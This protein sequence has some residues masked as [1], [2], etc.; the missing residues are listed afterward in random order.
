MNKKEILIQLINHLFDFEAEM[1]EQEDYTLEDFIGYMNSQ[2]SG[3]KSTIRKIG[4]DEEKWI[5]EK[6]VTQNSDIAVLLV[7]M[8]RY[9]KVYFKKAIK[10]SLIQ[11]QDEFSFLITLMTF[12]S[13]TKTE[14]IT[15]QIMEKT[16]GTEV[17]KRLLA[18]NLLKEFADPVDKRSVRVAVTD[19]GRNEIFKIL[20]DMGL[21]SKVV[22]GNL[23]ETETNT[24]AYLLKKLDHFH[25]DIYLNK[26]N[27]D[28]KDLLL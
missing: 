28:L 15:K 27:S 11:T 4:G 6:H 25:N 14:L 9:A 18:Q 24:L 16:S 20:P 5:E 17:I 13:L 21:A 23:N 26:R 2:S 12:E 8:S 7:L 1:P 10:N 22:V 19:K 3:S